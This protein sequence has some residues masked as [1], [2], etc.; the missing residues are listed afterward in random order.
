MD[1]YEEF[2]Q[3]ILRLTKIDLSAYKEKQMRRR[4]DSLSE[5]NN[6]T[7]YKQYHEL[8]KKD[9]NVYE[10]FINFLTINVSEFYRNKDQWEMMVK[11]YLPKL[12]KRFGSSLKVWSAACSTGDEPYSLV[13]ALSEVIDMKYIHILATDLDKQVIARAKT[14]VY[15]RKS[16][17]NVPQKFKDKY[18]EQIGDDSFKISDEIKRRVE[19]RQH[20]LLSDKYPTGYHFIV[21]RNVLIYFTEEAKHDIYEN[22]C[23]SLYKEGI[24]FIGSTEQVMDYRDIG[25]KRLSSFFYEKDK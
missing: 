21:C 16:I 13:M 24:L 20:N 17:L 7:S 23:S 4:I 6:C 25:Y 14:G 8:L 10:E 18:F 9:K 22:F 3:D 12:V 15:S 1:N 11:D 5:K 2:K 19:F